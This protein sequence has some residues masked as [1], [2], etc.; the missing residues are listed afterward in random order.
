MSAARDAIRETVLPQ[1][2]QRTRTPLLL[3]RHPRI[4][5]PA[6]DV[7]EVALQDAAETFT[8]MTVTDTTTHVIGYRNAHP[9]GREVEHLLG[10]R[11]VMFERTGI[12]TGEIV[13]IGDLLE[14]TTLTLAQRVLPSPA[15]AHWIHIV[16]QAPLICDIFQVHLQDLRL[17]HLIMRLPLIGWARKETHTRGDLH[18]LSSLSTVS[19]T[20]L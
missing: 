18:S 7:D 5:A 10:A 12:L 15:C 11:S 9:T 6:S 3:V 20:H 1:R 14:S 4:A 13:T 8:Q 19:Y 16:A 17:I 2:V